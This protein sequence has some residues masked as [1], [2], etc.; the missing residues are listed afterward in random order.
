MKRFLLV[1]FIS[2]SLT[3]LFANDT[4][5][6]SFGNTVFLDNSITNIQIADERIDFFLHNESFDVII[7]Y[8]YI[9][10]EEDNDLTL[11]FPIS[12]TVQSIDLN[13]IKIENF[14]T[15]FN[16]NTVTDYSE[17]IEKK[18]E[19]SFYYN[20]TKWY[21]R[22]LLFI[23][24][25][26]N[27]STISYTSSYSYSGS[28]RFA[29]YITGTASNWN[30][31][32][33]KISINIHL[34]KDII[35]QDWSI[36]NIKKSLSNA[37]IKSTQDGFSISFANYYPQTNDEITFGIAHYTPLKD[38]ENEFGDLHE[39]WIW[40]KY[41]LYIDSEEDKLLYTQEQLQL[42]INFFYAMHGYPFKT[43]TLKNYFINN[44]FIFS[45][46]KQKKYVENRNFNEKMF[47]EIEKKNIKY[48]QKMVDFYKRN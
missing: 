46:N 28:S 7:N 14:K 48:L 27:K 47:N 12:A 37:M 35:I 2:V 32:I 31:C 6:I 10:N 25:T 20:L 26:H 44:P 3:L 24:K 4:R 42:F 13:N 17:K 18:S 34:D 29:Q 5:V 45:D 22:K 40:D 11:G 16:G 1:G 8:D 15:I 9:N 19:D 36:P 39:G 33:K 38:Y 21:I 30:G 43:N 23:G 41:L